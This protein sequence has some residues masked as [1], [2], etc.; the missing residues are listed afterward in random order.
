MRATEHPADPASTSKSGL[1][2][3]RGL[4]HVGGIAAPKTGSG[5][6]APSRRR[7]LA[8]SA[9]LAATLGA[10]AFTSA[11]ALAA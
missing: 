9:A 6:D 5:T 1:A 7:A 3:L 11:P 2:T 4:L 10:L 8:A